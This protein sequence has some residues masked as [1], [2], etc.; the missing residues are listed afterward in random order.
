MITG[1]TDLDLSEDEMSVD[2]D[3]S[4]DDRDSETMR[5]EVNSVFTHIRQL[6]VHG[7]LSSAATQWRHLVSPALAARPGVRVSA[8]TSR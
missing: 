8:P 2:G 1:V 4:T 3:W 7:I 5:S 6:P